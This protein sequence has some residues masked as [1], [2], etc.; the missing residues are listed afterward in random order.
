MRL[1]SCVVLFAAACTSSS[2]GVD[3][4]PDDA[5]IG[6]D[7]GVLDA[8]PNPDAGVVTDAGPTDAGVY[9]SQCDLEPELAIPSDAC[10]QNPADAPCRLECARSLLGRDIDENFDSITPEVFAGQNHPI[11][12]QD[13]SIL[14]DLSAVIDTCFDVDQF[15]LG[16]LPEQDFQLNGMRAAAVHIGTGDASELRSFTLTRAQYLRDLRILEN[17][18]LE[19]VQIANMGTTPEYVLIGDNPRLCDIDFGAITEPTG[20]GGMDAV[21]WLQSLGNCVDGE[22]VVRGLC[23]TPPANE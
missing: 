22:L 9:V 18:N 14:E 3:V 10:V 13:M 8:G 19:R 17:P 20:C 1:M 4:G 2:S 6:G 15:R 5:G 21:T 12:Y 11:R 23:C 7:A 16:G